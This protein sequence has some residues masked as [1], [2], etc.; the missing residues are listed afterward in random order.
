M[1][2]LYEKYIKHKMFN[3]MLLIYTI[4]TITSIF[5]LCYVF[6]NY[7]IENELQNEL[8]IQS[9]VIFNIE[10]RF[11]EQN[12]LANSVANGINSQPRIVE[13]VSILVGSSYEEYF[14]HKLDN[15]QISGINNVDL[16]YV[17]DTILS[18]RKDALAVVVNDKNREFKSQFVVNRD[19]YY[20][21]ED[22]E[23][24][25]NIRKITK[26]IKNMDTMYTVG[27]IDVYFDLKQLSNITKAS[28]IR[29]DLIVLNQSN[30]IVFNSNKKI[31]YNDIYT[32]LDNKKYRKVNSKNS[33]VSIFDDN[34]IVEIKEDSTNGFKFMS[35]IDD[36]NLDTNKLILKII[37]LSTACIVSILLIT[38]TAINT[39][40][41]KLKKMMY[42][43]EKIK[44]G[45]LN[46]KIDIEEQEDELDMIAISINDMSESLEF[47][48]KNHYDAYVR[49]K[50]AKMSALQSQIKPHFLFNT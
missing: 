32:M 22:M 42:G 44:K 5:L 17:I 14:N 8:R 38:Y 6:I 25:D 23:I 26:P 34:P 39:Y 3:K 19:I 40:S 46:D 28:S 21:V 36:K 50:E 7:Y 37:C 45:D 4:I 16:R 15:F 30:Q 47:Y 24:N 29:G 48:I 10:K 1:K 12:S 9:E 35:I 27:Y 11:E 41:N 2:K 43:I 20:N 33:L 13:E 18:N 31:E 49:Q